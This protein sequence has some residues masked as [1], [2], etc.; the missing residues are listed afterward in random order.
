M[1]NDA[2]IYLS[3]DQKRNV[4]V[5]IVTAGDYVRYMLVTIRFRHSDLKAGEMDSSAGH[6]LVGIAKSRTRTHTHRKVLGL[7]VH[8]II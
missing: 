8:Y 6:Q 1:C 7:I 5:G 3:V 2:C 4:D